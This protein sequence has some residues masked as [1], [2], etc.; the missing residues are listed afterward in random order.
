MAQGKA[1][2]IIN[3]DRKPVAYNDKLLSLLSLH[4][5]KNTINQLERLIQ[6]NPELSTLFNQHQD[7]LY[8]H[9]ST[10]TKI[11][12][13][14]HV[15]II[16]NIQ[17][18]SIKYNSN[19]QYLL[20]NIDNSDSSTTESV[21]LE[22][23]LRYNV[24][25][26]LASSI[27]H[28]IRNPLSSLAIH[29]EVLDNTLSNFT[30]NQNE[31]QKIKKSIRIINSELNRVSKIIDQFFNL[32]R[33]NGNEMKYEDINKIILEILD[34]IKQQ[35][36]EQGIKV[37]LSLEKQIP[38][39]HIFR[40]LI[41]QALLNIIINSLEAMPEGGELLLSTVNKDNGIHII[42]KDNG[43]GMDHETKDRLFD[44]YY[45]TKENGGGIGLALSKEIIKRQQ[46]QIFIKSNQGIGSTFTVVL[47]QVTNY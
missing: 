18:Y 29:T 9:T 38:Y 10:Q 34:L 32:A 44:L 46:G 22:R 35:C 45:T 13:L 25:N 39:V 5:H 26:K 16:V 23:S 27:A 7:A 15:V 33:S 37:N 14:D 30:F 21:N 11:K 2:L 24:I 1:F 19:E 6:N 28:E 42:I 41:I 36:Y 8:T 12:L 47:P 31:K 43:C 17:I 3:E 20:I 4:P 40:N